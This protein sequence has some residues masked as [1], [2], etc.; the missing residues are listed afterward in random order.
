MIELKQQG[1]TFAQIAERLRLSLSCIKKFWRRFCHHGPP[2]LQPRSCCPK[3][4]HPQ[5][6]PDAVR[7]L[8]LQ[9]K[10]A[11]PHWGAQFIQGELRRRHAKYIPHRRTIER[12]LSHFPDLP[13]RRYQRRPALPDPRRATRLHQL[14]Q[15]DF[16]VNYRFK[17]SPHRASFLNIRDM[18][19][20]LCILTHTLPE[21]RSALSSQEALSVCRLA[22]THWGLL[23]EA[24]RTDH[25]A[26]FCAPE[27]ESFPT[28]FTLYLW[29]LGIEH[30]LIPVRRPAHN[31]G[32][33]R[34]QRT[35]SENFLADYPFHSHRQLAQDAQAFG[36]FRNRF[37]PSRSVRCQGQI[38]LAVAPHLACHAVAYNP[39]REAK[40]FDVHRIYDKL[41]SLRWRRRVG[42][43]GY[44][45]LGH[46]KY[47]VGRAY[48]RQVVHLHFA[49]QTLEV[50]MSTAHQAD[51]KRWPLRGLTYH[52]IVKGPR[53][54]R[55]RKGHRGSRKKAA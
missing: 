52:D 50:V 45:T 55:E 48:R 25:G 16:K 41:A 34:D 17:P 21:G 42:S 49:R 40:L 39:E 33:E 1:L 14:W 19:S 46:Q 3:T 22:F 5:Q 47:Y 24:I 23:P 43:S 27:P 8:I 51:L 38:P 7:R 2:G 4:P 13:K 53:V 36:H 32:I 26:C 35:L 9:I 54:E 11:H 28:D 6:T 44:V 37:V 20:T 29:G 12:F 18:A 15:M 31:G 30:E 10:S